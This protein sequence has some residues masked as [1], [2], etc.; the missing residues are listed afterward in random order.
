MSNSIQVKRRTA[1]AT[2]PTAGQLAVGELAFNAVDG[3]LYSKKQDGSVIFWTPGAGSSVT[4]SDTPPGSPT[5]G[6]LWWDST[7][8]TMRV[9]YASSS[10]W[11][12]AM[13]SAASFDPTAPGPI[14]SGTPS[15]GAFTSLTINGAT[16]ATLGKAAALALIF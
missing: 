4:I 7:T 6:N 8:G 9:Y 12:D 14:G 2:A 3:K 11:V 5:N 1:D 16:V 15:T 10:A 13:P